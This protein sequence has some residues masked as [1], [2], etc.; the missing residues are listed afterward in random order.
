MEDLYEERAV[1]LCVQQLQDRWLGG[2]SSHGIDFFMISAIFSLDTGEFIQR[3]CN[4]SKEKYQF[5]PF[6][7]DL[8]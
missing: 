8:N 7:L 5:V 1:E 4:R 6:G 3:V 2:Y